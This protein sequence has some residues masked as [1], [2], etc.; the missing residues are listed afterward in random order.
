MGRMSG[1]TKLQRWLD[2]IAYLAGRRL[3]VAGDELLSRIPAYAAGWQSDEPRARESARRKF[4]RD[5]D[6]LRA[7]GI[8]IQTVRYT[9]ELGSDEIEGYR[10]DRRDFYL[11]YLRLVERYSGTAR[12]ESRARVAD[13]EITRADA[14]LALEALRR[15]RDL[16]A[17]PLAAEA[18]SAYRKLAFDLDPEAH[19]PEARVLYLERPG[20][21][22]LLARLRTLSDALL[23][24][25]RVSFRYHGIYRGQETGR[26]V[27]PYGLLFQGGNWYLVGHD[28]L[29]AELRVFRVGR[30]EDVQVNERAPGTP[31]YQIPAD[32]R[33]RAYAERRPWE[34][35]AGDEPPLAAR[36]RFRF[37]LSLWAERNRYGRLEARLPDG[38]TVRS[39]ELQ[40]TQPFLRWLL[41][42]EGEA[43]ILEP[44][45]LRAELRNITAEIAA[46]HREANDGDA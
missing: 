29:R 5:K 16:P 41:A 45:E 34:L 30:I 26:D 6:E 23:T 3:P 22:A 1:P 24:R 9:T 17:F 12:Y 20:S 36:V 18:R 31:D 35:G 19:A 37:P 40:Q 4:E 8:P 38:A 39:F 43:E 25:K 42:T 46:A 33:L 32:F 7:Q 44:P 27:A 15:A 10:I 21:A 28:A 13:V 11:P 2:L 14:P